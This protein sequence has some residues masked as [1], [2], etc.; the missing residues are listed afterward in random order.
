MTI[1]VAIDGVLRSGHRVIREGRIL[2]DAFQQAKRRIVFMSD[3]SVETAEHWL[4]TSGFYD[5]AGIFSPAMAVDDDEPLWK[6]HIAAARYMGN[7]D[8]VISG[9]PEVIAH[10]LEIRV[11]SLLFAHPESA[12]PE[13]R[14]D[15][16][17]RSWSDITEQLSRSNA[18]KLKEATSSE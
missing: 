10:C 6:R 2:F 13:W 14:P 12:L 9:D 18:K 5:Y 4:G 11:P 1:L 7:V 3:E 16:N 8:L 17:V 15:S